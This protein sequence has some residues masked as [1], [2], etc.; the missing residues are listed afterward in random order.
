MS[1]F[2]AQRAHLF[3]LSVAMILVGSPAPVVAQVASSAGPTCR[4][5]NIAVAVVDGGP[6]QS[7]LFGQLCYAGPRIPNTVQLLVHGI[8]TNHLYWDFPL[9]NFYYSYVRAVTSAGYATF[10]V[11]R[12]GAGA[13]SRPL[14]TTVNLSSGTTA[15]HSLI[16]QLRSGSAVGHVFSHVL[17]VGH[18]FG[19]MLAWTEVARYHDVDGLIVTG[20]LHKIS[21]TFVQNALATASMPAS[22]DAKFEGLGLDPGYLTTIPGTR[23]S[24]LFFTPTTDPR[25]LAM[26]EANKDTVTLA[27]LAT[28]LPLVQAPPPDT[29]PSRQIDVP[30]LDVIGQRDSDFCAPDAVDCSGV[31]SV[32]QVEAPYYSSQASYALW[33]SRRRGTR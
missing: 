3:V 13:S 7:A 33:S 30:V 8:I 24:L 10:N 6:P 16:Q 32:R 17:W 29:S 1:R 27:E 19:A 26:D 18:S 22:L 28:G 15:L 2:A 31:E 9:D 20:A 23:S 21:P 25:V 14:S 5:Y 12:I 11:D 4:D